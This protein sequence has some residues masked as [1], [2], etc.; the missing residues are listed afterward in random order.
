MG[1]L[2]KVARAAATEL[3]VQ[4]ELD[5]P[6]AAP[7]SVVGLADQETAVEAARVAGVVQG[8]PAVVPA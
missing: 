5:L 7:S 3:V 2:L 4:G 1:E 6:E 8:E